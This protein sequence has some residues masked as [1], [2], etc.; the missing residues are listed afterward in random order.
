MF[1]VK[2][3]IIMEMCKASPLHSKCR[4]LHH[5]PPPTPCPSPLSGCRGDP[6]GV[7]I[8]SGKSG[9]PEGSDWFLPDLS[10]S[11]AC[12]RPTRGALS[13]PPAP[14]SL[15]ALSVP[16]PAGPTIEGFRA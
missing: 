8:F 6:A 15:S 2:I 14:R 11:P 4:P 12:G 13:G 7:F 10:W 16:Q 1:S 5:P 3:Q 9:E